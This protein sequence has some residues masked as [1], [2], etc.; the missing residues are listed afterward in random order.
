MY[1]PGFGAAVREMVDKHMAVVED[2][3]MEDSDETDL[4]LEFLQEPLGDEW[5]DARDPSCS[6]AARARV[7]VCACVCVCVSVCLCVCLCVCVVH[8][9]WVATAP[10]LVAPPVWS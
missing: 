7:C 5:P 9:T 2:S 1:Q 3:S 4:I 10:L 8:A 6:L